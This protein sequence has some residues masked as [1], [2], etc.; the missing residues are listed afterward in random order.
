MNWEERHHYLLNGDYENGW[1]YHEEIWS[2][3][4]KNGKYDAS[5]YGKPIWNGDF[6]PITLLINAEFG[7]GDTLQFFR[8]VELAKKRVKKVILK[9]NEDFKLLFKDIEINGRNEELPQ[10]DKVI[11]MM[12]LARVLNVKKEDISGE[13][14]IE[15]NLDFAPPK[16]T[17][18][19]SLYKFHKFGI[20]WAGSPFCYRDPI[21]SI[22]KDVFSRFNILDVLI[23]FSFN[24]LNEPPSNCFD[25][26][27]IML[28]WNDTAHLISQM[29]LVITVDTSV[30]HLAG[31]MGIP[32][33]LL[34]STSNP[35][36][37]WGLKGS[38]TFWYDSMKLYRFDQ[39]WENTM[40]LVAHDFKELLDSLSSKNS[41]GVS[42]GI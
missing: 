4:P 39:S 41:T 23:F 27:G 13:K 15:A 10:F 33:W 14:Y 36:W 5:T 29:T 21:R 34:I 38:D 24:A 18:L 3:D 9:C 25:C 20:N 6:E 22:N 17:Q 7:D 19:F 40:D 12:A 42:V 28:N 37:R 8:F 35:E 26:R 11:H 31:A 32:V 30:A 2:C 16:E 1:P